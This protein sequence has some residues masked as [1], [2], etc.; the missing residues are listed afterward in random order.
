MYKF[1]IFPIG[2]D[3]L[4]NYAVTRNK[5]SFSSSRAEI[6]LELELRETTFL[7]PREA[8][9]ERRCK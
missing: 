7:S 5:I 9:L 8:F 4:Y 3:S 6:S 2:R 1:S